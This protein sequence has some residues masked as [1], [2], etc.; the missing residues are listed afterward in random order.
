M[1]IGPSIT[2]DLKDWVVRVKT[3]LSQDKS[4]DK[5]VL[6]GSVVPLVKV[7]GGGEYLSVRC[8]RSRRLGRQGED[9]PE[10]PVRVGVQGGPL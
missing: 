1:T 8:G 5:R 10:T 3:D 2:D 6:C 4:K 7:G 9:D